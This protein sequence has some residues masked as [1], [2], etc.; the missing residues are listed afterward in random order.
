MLPRMATARR[1]TAV[2]EPAAPAGER[3]PHDAPP[4]ERRNMRLMIG[5]SAG[6]SVKHFYQQTL[7][8]LLPHIKEALLLS[9]VAAGG[10]IGV[11]AAAMGR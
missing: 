2:A 10:I 3:T 5:L 4:R 8:L 1:T 9:D 7:L 6:H 11:R